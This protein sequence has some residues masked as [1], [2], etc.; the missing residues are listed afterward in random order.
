MIINYRFKQNIHDES[1]HEPDS[2]S[3]KEPISKTE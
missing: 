1:M 3:V 2:S